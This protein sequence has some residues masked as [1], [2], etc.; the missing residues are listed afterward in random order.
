MHFVYVRNINLWVRVQ[1]AKSTDIDPP[2][3]NDYSTVVYIKAKLGECEELFKNSSSLIK[4]L[5]CTYKTVKCFDITLIKKN[6]NKKVSGFRCYKTWTESNQ[7]LA[8]ID[9]RL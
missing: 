3:N 7:R 2:L 6:K 1:P 8:A 9:L 5:D 4:K